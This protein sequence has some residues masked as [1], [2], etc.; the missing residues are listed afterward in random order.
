MLTITGIS[1]FNDNYIWMLTDT[2][3][4][5]CYIVDPGDHLV[6]ENACQRSNLALAGILITH[7]HADHTGGISKLTQKRNIPVYGPASE[8]ITGITHR[9]HDG[10]KLTIFNTEWQ[11]MTTAGHTSGHI[12]YF[13]KLNNQSPVLFSGDTLFGGGC[14]R[15]FEGTAEQM[16]ASL[17]R[18][19]ALPDDTQIYCAHEYTQANLA[20]A[21]V[22]EPNNQALQQRIQWVAEQRHKQ[23]PTVPFSLAGERDTNPFLRTSTKMVMDAATLYSGRQVETDVDCFTIIRQWKDNF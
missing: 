9:L 3:N 4:Q 6:V 20:F 13:G 17:K 16:H 22:V 1:A 5:S 15:L 7:H 23:Q 2:G 10:D 14:G 12:C 11:V 18:L 21:Q 19:Q 8:S